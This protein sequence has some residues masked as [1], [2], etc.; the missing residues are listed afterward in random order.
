MSPAR[1]MH[2]NITIIFSVFSLFLIRRFMEIRQIHQE[3]MKES[4]IQERKHSRRHSL[5]IVV[6][7]L[8]AEQS[9]QN[10]IAY[11]L[12]IIFQDNQRQQFII[13]YINNNYN[14]LYS[15]IRTTPNP[16]SFKDLHLHHNIIYISYTF[17]KELYSFNE[18]FNYFMTSKQNQVNN[19]VSRMKPIFTCSFFFSQHEIQE[20]LI[21]RNLNGFTSPF[22]F[23]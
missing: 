12:Y 13:C 14:L 22:L 18:T 6:A 3:R 2:T 1:S 11:K 20:R 4:K 8:T 15:I 23:C 19:T 21:G 7:V 17:Q 5:I 9:K 16:C 10:T